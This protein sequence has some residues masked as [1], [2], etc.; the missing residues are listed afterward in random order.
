MAVGRPRGHGRYARER[1]PARLADPGGLGR[2]DWSDTADR[3]HGDVLADLRQTAITIVTSSRTPSV[4][5]RTF[6]A[7]LPATTNS[8]RTSSPPSLSP[9][10]SRSG[11]D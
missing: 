9:P 10:S 3:D 2:P 4:G 7:S 1:D 8:P 6:A 11:Y 5:L